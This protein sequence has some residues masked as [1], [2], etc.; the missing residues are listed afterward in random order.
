MLLKS[1][2]T[3]GTQKETKY[4]EIFNWVVKASEGAAMGT[5]TTVTHEVMHGNYSKLP[6]PTLQKIMHKNL[7][8][9]GGIKYS[10][11]ENEYAKEIYKTMVA[12]GNSHW[13]SGKN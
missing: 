12:P 9:R 6:N 5:E 10:S 1:I 4:N 3:L 11:E 8:S 2:I 7:V 13:R